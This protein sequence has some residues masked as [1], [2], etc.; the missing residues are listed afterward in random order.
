MKT[1]AYGGRWGV[2]PQKAAAGLW[3]TPQDLARL[4]MAVQKAKSG[5]AAGP[6]SPAIAEEFLT[7]Q[8]DGP[9]GIG[10]FLDGEGENRGFFHAG[11][12][13]GYFAHFGA[14]VSK[15][16]AWII[17]TNAQKDRFDPIVK[18]IAEEFRWLQ[19]DKGTGE[20]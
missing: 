9:T 3:T 17:M 18:A 19:A 7:R 12:N 6:I 1:V 10:I 14:G 13:P 5:E 20:E 2:F 15:D 4:I 16:R 8:F 11:E